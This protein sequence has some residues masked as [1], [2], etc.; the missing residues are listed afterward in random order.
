[1]TATAA[2]LIAAKKAE[3]EKA[4][5][6]V[7]L[8]DTGWTGYFASVESMLEFVDRAEAQGRPVKVG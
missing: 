5:L 2:D 3:R 6:K 1:M 4:G 8:T 7:T